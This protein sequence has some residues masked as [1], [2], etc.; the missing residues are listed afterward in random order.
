[1]TSIY[2]ID[3]PGG[4]HLI[5]RSPVPLWERLPVVRTLLAPGDK[6]TFVPVSL[7]EYEELIAQAAAGTLSVESVEESVGV[8]A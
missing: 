5:G 2:P 7:R 4:W 3:H 8:A 1:M 6:V